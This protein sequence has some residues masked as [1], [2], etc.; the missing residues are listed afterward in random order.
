[1]LEA[2]AAFAAP[3]S[4]TVPLDAFSAPTT[5]PGHLAASVSRDGYL[6]GV[7]LQ[8][9]SLITRPVP[10]VPGRVG[11][12]PDALHG[13]WRDAVVR[14]SSLLSATGLNTGSGNGQ[15]AVGATPV[16]T[17]AEERSLIGASSVRAVVDVLGAL[18]KMRAYQWDRIFP[19][20]PGTPKSTVGIEHA[21]EQLVPIWMKAMRSRSKSEARYIL[22][23]LVAEAGSGK[24]YIAQ[25]LP[26][27]ASTLYKKQRNVKRKAAFASTVS[28][29]GVNFNST[30]SILQ[31]EVI[32][33]E[34]GTLT[35]A[36][37]WRLRLLFNHYADLR[38]KD[39]SYLFDRYIAGVLW[40]LNEGVLS[41]N[42]I[43]NEALGVMRATAASKPGEVAVLLVDEPAKAD[44]NMPALR[45]FIRTNKDDYVHKDG[46]LPAASEILLASMC[47]VGDRSRVCVCSTSLTASTV[48]KAATP[49]GRPVEY[50]DISRDDPTDLA[51]LILDGLVAL[52][53]KRM[54]LSRSTTSTP[55]LYEL[56]ALCEAHAAA[57]SRAEKSYIKLQ[58]REL[59]RDTAIGLSYCAS[60][61]LRTAVRLGDA[62][63]KTR[64][65]MLKNFGEPV[66]ELREV[67]VIQAN[68]NDKLGA[69]DQTSGDNH[70]GIPDQTDCDD[71]TRRDAR[72][73]VQDQK[74]GSDQAGVKDKTRGGSEGVDDKRKGSRIA[75]KKIIDDVVVQM[76]Q[77]V[78]EQYWVDAAGHPGAL[79]KMLAT[80]VLSKNV[81]HDAICL[82]GAKAE[83]PPITWDLAR[84][85]GLVL[86]SGRSFRPR[87]SVITM[88]KLIDR[89]E[90]KK[91]LFH[92]IMSRQ[93]GHTVDQTA[94]S[95]GAEGGAW[96][97]WESFA[98]ETEVS[99]AIARSLKGSEYKSV[100]LKELMVSGE[101]AY[102]GKG[103]LLNEVM[104]DAS[105]PR[106]GVV[107]QDIKSLLTL[108]DHDDDVLDYVYR[109]PDNFPGI[110][111]VMFFRCVSAPHNV[112]LAGK[113]IAVVVQYK[114]SDDA[115]DT[116]LRGKEIL[117]DWRKIEKELF[118]VEPVMPQN[119][120][121]LE[122][123]LQLIKET[124]KDRIVYLNVANR[125][126]L[127]VKPR[128][129]KSDGDFVHHC[130]ANAVVLGRKH[131][132]SLL[133]RTYFDFSRGMDWVFG[134]HVVRF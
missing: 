102:A 113:N 110:D 22:S 32:A 86:G 123:R 116:Y 3:V 10:V 105:L 130:S 127:S 104:V 97:R 87:L 43:A 108:S 11:A 18:R 30:F 19:T 53:L 29:L 8:Q 13:P 76:G 35:I 100:S 91:L 38:C 96:R 95:S 118:Q 37:L 6:S 56:V 115:A 80:L 68:G 89:E 59:L 122:N 129:S 85:A 1:M 24:S 17:R 25:Q 121:L 33:I 90:S 2:S 131:M 71:E 41:S 134:C 12:R 63:G 74:R 132:G 36:D 55:A 5:T 42:D 34:G 47:A 48:I 70:A 31:E 57:P 133:G 99:H 92:D 82:P 77:G 54:Y 93:L 28:F 45:K 69:K 67:S 83:D 109:L 46:Y 120:F 60:A 72:A 26:R 62:I 44:D 61:H 119:R 107:V 79:D 65:T 81:E 112:K 9:R 27:Q 117:N 126:C 49:S 16:L 58:M 64:L 78:A 51:E 20:F 66:A 84:R 128:V 52:T 103:R 98:P 39:V 111:A 4:F 94:S 40:A 23:G 7:K 124:W 21:M 106:K 14:V 125:K 88:L 73:G 75:V 15:P 114:H 50:V 101:C